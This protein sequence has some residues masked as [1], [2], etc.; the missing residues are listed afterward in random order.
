MSQYSTPLQSPPKTATT[1]I[2]P[3]PAGYYTPPTEAKRIDP[4]IQYEWE[5]TKSSQQISRSVLISEEQPHQDEEVHTMELQIQTENL[6]EEL[7]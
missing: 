1:T 3:T 2:P 4:P 6:L 5:E 7:D